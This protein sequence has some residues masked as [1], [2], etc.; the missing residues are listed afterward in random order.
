[1]SDE[2]GAGSS[3]TYD[4]E[5]DLEQRLL[6][7]TPEHTTRGI[8]FTS[9]LNMVRILGADEA[10]VR[11]CQEASGETQFVDFFNYPTSSLL[12]LMGAAA[13]A[14][15]PQYGSFEEVLRRIGQMAGQSFMDSVVGRSAQQMMIGAE[16]PLLLVRTF[17]SLYKVVL[18]Y[19][20]PSVVWAG[21]KRGILAVQRTFTP[22]PF[23]EGGAVAMATRLGVKNVK[24]RAK[25]TGPLSI[26]LEVSWD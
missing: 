2:T 23:H 5:R 4:A 24:A 13:R 25:S 9:T 12:R 17:Q 6:L 7:A 20:E 14:L 10:M 8:L 16:D 1:M 15:S 11:Q 18:V 26:E 21:P 22:L 19:S 3:P